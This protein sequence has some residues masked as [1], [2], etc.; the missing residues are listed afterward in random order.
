MPG[1]TIHIQN[2]EATEMKHF[3]LNGWTQIQTENELQLNRW[4]Y[5]Q[6]IFSNDT[7]TW[8]LLIYFCLLKI[9]FTW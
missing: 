4:I 8:E 7:Q 2:L 6:E 3:T 1:S 5:H 9:I